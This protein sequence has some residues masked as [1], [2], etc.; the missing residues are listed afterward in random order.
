MHAAFAG[1]A[2]LDSARESSYGSVLQQVL[3]RSICIAMEAN[4]LE[5]QQFEEDEEGGFDELAEYNPDAEET[6]EDR[7][8]VQR[9]LRYGRIILARAHAR[10]AREAAEAAARQAGLE[11]GRQEGLL[12][13]RREVL[14]HLLLRGG[15]QPTEA[16]QQRIAECAE[17]ALLDRWIDQAIGAS[18]VAASLA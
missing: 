8:A 1:L 18:S 7:E 12:L 3:G 16:E 6:D 13:S 9:M 15:L 14:M 10:A 2:T 4:V 5:T 17:P 11:A